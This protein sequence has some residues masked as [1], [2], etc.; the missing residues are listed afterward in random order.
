[1]RIAEHPAVM[2]KSTPKPSIFENLV[3][4]R[5]VVKVKNTPNT[6]LAKTN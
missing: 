1:L 2:P 3:V 5:K 6:W 4:K